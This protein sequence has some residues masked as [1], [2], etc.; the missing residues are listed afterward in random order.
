MVKVVIKKKKTSFYVPG[1]SRN[2][3]LHHEDSNPFEEFYFRDTFDNQRQFGLQIAKT[4]LDLT[5][6]IVL[7]IA[8][9]QSG[10]TGSMLSALYHFYNHSEL[11][12]PKENIFII[13]AHSSNEW[14]VQTKSRFP[15][16]MKS[17]IYHRNTLKHFVK[18]VQNL[19]NVIII[20]D[21]AHIAANASQTLNLIFKQL[22]F[23]DLKHLCNN[24][25]K[26]LLFTA[27]PNALT[28]DILKWNEYHAILHMQNIP[29]LYKSYQFYNDNLLLLPM[30]DLSDFDWVQFKTNPE[31]LDNIRLILDVIDLNTPK[32]HIIRTH[33]S[34]KHF[35]TIY[36]FIHAF[37]KHNFKF[38]S[39]LYLEDL[40]N[41][42]SIQPK[43]H[44][45][46]FIKDKLRCAKTLNHQHLLV[47]YERFTT[48]SKSDTILQGLLGRATGIHPFKHVVFST[49]NFKNTNL[50]YSFLIN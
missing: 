13:T 34:N 49:L 14:V 23:Y 42:L 40:D 9:T 25:I 46:I 6:L 33:R 19:K 17:H 4:F 29:S 37:S 50:P 11:K 5:K 10:K 21:E 43:V 7:A 36:N 27:T 18:Q 38:I 3:Q 47:L 22:N 39:E 15:S 35:V 44:T 12:M 20:I 8:P 24:N 31:T 26:F 16:F 1:L 48:K 30:R 41:I 28:R 45:F 2:I 32:Y